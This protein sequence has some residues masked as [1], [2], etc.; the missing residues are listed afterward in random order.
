MSDLIAQAK[1]R[2][3]N[4]RPFIS[5]MRQFAIHAAPPASRV[6]LRAT[7]KGATA[8]GKSLGLELPK[9]PSTSTKKSEK[10]AL[11]LGPDEWLIIDE[12]SSDE[13]M[14]PRLANKEFSAVDVSHRNA[15][16]ILSGKG[17]ENTLNAGCPRDLSLPG[18]SR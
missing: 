8:F 18:I 3:P 7:T 15:A 11:W 16:Y 10:T 2:T 17:A 9:K 6:S 13:T 14:V 5:Q 4:C 12:K 1:R